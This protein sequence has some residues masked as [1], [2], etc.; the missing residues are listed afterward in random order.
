MARASMAVMSVLAMA[1]AAAPFLACGGKL[2]GVDLYGPPAP[3]QEQSGTKENDPNEPQTGEKPK[4]PIVPAGAPIPG[5]A[6]CQMYTLG[7]SS[8]CRETTAWGSSAVSFCK[9]VGLDF[10]A[11]AFQG[12]CGPDKTL[13]VDVTC[14]EPVPSSPK[15]KPGEPQPVA[16]EDHHIGP[17]EGK[18]CIRQS[19]WLQ[20]ASDTC[21]ATGAKVEYIGPPSTRCNPPS[22]ATD[23][24]KFTCCR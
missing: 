9:Q 2:A 19:M 18:G 23:E 6:G 1:G 17:D 13:G 5:A 7:D 22:D 16:C 14:C 24:I 15:D 4:P 10:T 21:A 20:I 11:A 8:S 12:S 3:A